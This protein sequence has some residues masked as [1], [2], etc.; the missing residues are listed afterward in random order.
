MCSNALSFEKKFAEPQH[1]TRA[2]K[3]DSRMADQSRKCALQRRFCRMHSS[4]ESQ[5]SR[6]WGKLMAV[7]HCRH[8]QRSMVESGAPKPIA[9]D[10]APA[11]ASTQARYMKSSALRTTSAATQR[12]R[13]FLVH[14]QVRLGDK[15]S[16][17]RKPACSGNQLFAVFMARIRCGR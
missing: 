16:S 11:T 1:C 12:G 9:H 5:T 2:T 15:L 14:P 8:P 17:C 4:S 13:C 3:Y 6:P 7:P 10:E